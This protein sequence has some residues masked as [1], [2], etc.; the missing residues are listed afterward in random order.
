MWREPLGVVAAI[1]AWNFPMILAM[2]KLAPALAMGNSI[3]I[4]PASNTPLSTL[5]LAELATEAGIPDGVFNVV[6][7]PGSSVGNALVTHPSVDKVAFTGSTEVGRRIMQQASGTVKRVTLELGGKSP[8]IVLPDADLDVT[9][10]GVLFGFLTH[11]GQVCE[12][13]TRVLVHDSMY[14]EVVEQLVETAKSIKIGDPSHKETGMGPVVSKQQLDTILSYIESG[15]QEGARL[16]CGGKR[17]TVEGF[18]NGYFL[19]PTILLHP[20]INA[21]MA[22]LDPELT[23]GL[24]PRITAFTG[25]D[26]LTHAVEAYFSPNA[27]P[28]TDAYTLQSIRIVVDNLKN[29]VHAGNDLTARANMLMASSMAISAYCLCLNAIPVHNIA[30]ALGA[31]FSIPHGLANAVLLPTVMESMPMFYL[32]RIKGFAEALGIKNLPEQPEACL[33]EVIQYIRDLR[34]EVNLPDTFAE[35]NLDAD[36]LQNI[37]S[38]VHNDPSGVFYRIPAETINKIV[39]EVSGLSVNVL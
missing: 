5:K 25:F 27:N 34:N 12:S 31:Q 29:T 17:I 36:K 24:P 9:V 8:A 16:V 11:S 33:E 21:D 3:V 14:N 30:H 15:I 2:W 39:N 20:F 6:P 35:F 38:V 7:G 1:T 10:P 23:V 19:E 22:I 37:V 4:K 13:G 18:E 26:A 28:M 32:P